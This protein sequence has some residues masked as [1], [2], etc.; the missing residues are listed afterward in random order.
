MLPQVA[1]LVT[2]TQNLSTAADD[3]AKA[4]YKKLIAKNLKTRAALLAELQGYVD[5][6]A[7]TEWGTSKLSYN[8]Q[9]GSV[10][11]IWSNH[12]N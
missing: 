2:N 12:A 5:M 3:E 4:L 11:S 7:E 1:A 9:I 10:E 6:Y 8:I